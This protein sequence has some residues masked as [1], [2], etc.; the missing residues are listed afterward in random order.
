MLQI[1]DLTG[2]EFVGKLYKKNA[3]KEYFSKQQTT[4]STPPKHL[5]MN[6]LPLHHPY[7]KN[8][9]NDLA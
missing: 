3:Q 4:T 9:E 8:N 1:N 7:K 5:C 6:T 2:S